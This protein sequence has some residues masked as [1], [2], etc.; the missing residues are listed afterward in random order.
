MPVD[1][2]PHTV[3]GQQFVGDQG[4]GVQLRVTGPGGAVVEQ[5]RHQAFGGD[6][7]T[8]SVPRRDNPAWESRY[9]NAAVTAARCAS[10]TWVC[11]CHPAQSPQCADT[12][13]CGERQVET[14]DRIDS[15][16]PAQRLTGDWVQ[17]AGE[18]RLQ[19]RLADLPAGLQAELAEAAADPHAGLFTLGQVVLTR[20]VPTVFW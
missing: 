5:R 10:S 2:A 20:P 17:G 3:R 13:G 11:R 9:A 15:P 4:V 18:D 7:L 19:L 1:G 8:P 16:R 14:G 6:L 12:L